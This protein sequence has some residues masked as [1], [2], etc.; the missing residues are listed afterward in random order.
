M[1][2]DSLRIDSENWLFRVLIELDDDNLLFVGLTRFEYLSDDGISLCLTHLKY[3][4]VTEILWQ[5][6]IR[7]FKNEEDRELSIRRFSK[8][9]HPSSKC[10]QRPDSVENSA[11]SNSFNVFIRLIATIGI[12]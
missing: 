10:V 5:G 7:C 8:L 2:S 12:P 3:H 6:F 1:S 4:Q 9:F 11:I